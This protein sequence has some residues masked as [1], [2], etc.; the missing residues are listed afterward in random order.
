MLM[1]CSTWL[2]GQL[3]NEET[4]VAK[5]GESFLLEAPIINYLAEEPC[6][7]EGCLSVFNSHVADIGM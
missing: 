3:S 5:S 7:L 2:R 4:G 1:K 6:I